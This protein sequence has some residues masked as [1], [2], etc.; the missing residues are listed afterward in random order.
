MTTLVNPIMFQALKVRLHVIFLQTKLTIF[1]QSRTY[2][3][4]AGLNLIW[5]PTVYLCTHCP[6]IKYWKII[7]NDI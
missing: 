1:L 7:A 3:L 6:K 2:F 5:I 4:F